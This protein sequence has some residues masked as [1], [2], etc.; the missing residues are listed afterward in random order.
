MPRRLWIALLV[1]ALVAPTLAQARQLYPV[2]E[3]PRDPSFLRFRQRLIAAAKQRDRRYI[4][5]IVDPKIRWSFGADTGK[6]GFKQ[7]WTE[8]APGALETELIQILSL[9][10]EFNSKGEFWVPYVFS[11]WPDQFDAFEHQAITGKNVS[12]RQR[13]DLAA[14]VIVR[15][16][17]EI[18]K[19]APDP[20]PAQSGKSSDPGEWVKIVTPAGRQGFVAAGYVRSPIDYRAC[21]K[22][23]GGRW[24]MTVLVAGD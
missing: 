15:L 6:Q 21:F 12:I 17:Y 19:R 1:L 3:G 8:A 7:H 5:S 4:Y 10:G 2:D 11:H 13:P 24:W 20:S 18:V 16:S 22:K 14:P 23:R 9:G